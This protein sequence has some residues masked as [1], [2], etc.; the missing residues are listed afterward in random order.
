MFE[1]NAYLTGA[2]CFIILVSFFLCSSLLVRRT[3]PEQ[4][5]DVSVRRD[6]AAGN[7][8]HG[9]VDGVEPELGFF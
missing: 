5:S 2:F 4:Q 8:L 6:P 9:L 3:R 1:T 7:L